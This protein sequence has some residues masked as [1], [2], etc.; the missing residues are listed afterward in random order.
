[1]SIP[2]NKADNKT[3]AYDIKLKRTSKTRTDP[4]IKDGVLE[5]GE[6]LFNKEDLTLS[7]GD[8]TEKTVE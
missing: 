1:M 5:D 4:T 7:I 2:A 3:P 6:P 8:G